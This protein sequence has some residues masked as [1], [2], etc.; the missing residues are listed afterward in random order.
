MKGLA[1][2]V[3]AI[4]AVLALSL[5]QARAGLISVTFDEPQLVDNDPLLTFYDGGTTYRGISGGPN[6]GISFSLNA[7]ERT[8]TSALTGTF[9]PPGIMQLYSDTARE[10]E[11]ISAVMD[12]AGGFI[13]S[14]TFF[15]AAIDADGKMTVYSG[16]DGT[17]TALTVLTL[18]VTSPLTGPG[19]FV[20][21]DVAF[22]GIA[23]SIV[24]DGGNKQLAIDDIKLTSAPEPPAWSLLLIGGACCWAASRLRKAGLAPART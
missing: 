21:D 19:V 4:S 10:G 7:R 3:L 15:Y 12:V 24:F 22:S 6:L 11:G 1:Q 14:A 2:G 18:P 23:H 20:A 8:M 16:L 17:G 5:G 13:S 9:T